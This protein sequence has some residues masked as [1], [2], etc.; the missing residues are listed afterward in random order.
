M[1]IILLVFI[2]SLFS[3]VWLW[4]GVSYTVKQIGTDEIWSLNPSD[5]AMLVT[6]ISAPILISVMIMVL[7][8]NHSYIKHMFGNQQ[9]FIGLL[10]RKADFLEKQEERRL[11]VSILGRLDKYVADLHGRLGRLIVMAGIIEAEDAQKTWQ[12]FAGGLQDVFANYF[13]DS[14]ISGKVF[15]RIEAKLSQDEN[16]AAEIEQFCC[17]Y[18]YV[19]ELFSRYDTEQMELQLFDN[20]AL[21]KA[22]G[23]IRKYCK[24]SG[25]MRSEKEDMS[26]SVAEEED[27]VVIDWRETRNELIDKYRGFAGS[28][29]DN[30]KRGALN[31]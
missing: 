21:S 18:E 6:G 8:Y 25:N 12:R 3:G 23:K 5:L 22:Y 27:D 4:L 31:D 16:F 28:V 19:Y 29:K 10:K 9:A 30:I 15:S 14:R 17:E 24:S 11:H 20:S 7:L 13:F 2:L 26:V 1:G